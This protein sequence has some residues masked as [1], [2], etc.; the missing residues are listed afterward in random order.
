MKVTPK[1]TEKAKAKSRS[2]NTFP[3]MMA[4]KIQQLWI[5]IP[6]LR[7]D[8]NLAV[9]VVIVATLKEEKQKN[10]ETQMSGETT[11]IGD[12]QKM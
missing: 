12:Y 10:K 6:N 8:N 1:K 3:I 11:N 7:A 5:N 2:F 9:I 4:H